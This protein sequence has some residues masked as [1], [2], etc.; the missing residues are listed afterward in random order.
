MAFVILNGFNRY[1]SIKA[2]ARLLKRLRLISFDLVL[3][4][5]SGPIKS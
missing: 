2:A 4:R 3:F 1:L 5:L